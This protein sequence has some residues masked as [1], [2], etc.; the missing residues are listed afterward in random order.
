MARLKQTPL[1]SNNRASTSSAGRAAPSPAARAAQ[2][3]PRQR[4]P[5]R[6]RPGTK[7]LME[8][9]YYQKTCDLLIP[10]LPFARYVKEITSMYASDV[11]RWTAEALTALQEATEDYIVHLFE[12][13]NLCAIH[14]KRVT[15][16]PKDLQLARRL[17]GVIE[18]AS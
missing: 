2:R 3:A 1:R 5:H 10:R 16:M 4:K 14:A 13:T 8:I 18:K 15:I 6:W 9:R 12:D 11:S 17:R 7:A